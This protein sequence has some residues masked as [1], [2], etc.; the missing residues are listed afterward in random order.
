MEPVNG[1]IGDN[2]LTQLPTT[3]PDEKELL[4]E[5]RTA[6]YTH[7]PE[8]KKQKE[9]W[10]ERIMFYQTYLP[11][12]SKAIADATSQERADNWA[13]ANLVIRELNTLINYYDNVKQGVEDGSQDS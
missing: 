9:Y 6:R 4:E 1:I 12:G 8:Y 2:Q 7:T 11:D 10:Q 3:Q 13:V 5:N